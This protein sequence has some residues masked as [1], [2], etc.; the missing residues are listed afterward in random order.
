MSET[1]KARSFTDA[2]LQARRAKRAVLTGALMLIA[3]LVLL[4]TRFVIYM[5]SW[6]DERPVYLAG[7]GV[8]L[9]FTGTITLVA[10]IVLSHISRN[11]TNR[12]LDAEVR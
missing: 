4:L 11:E 5:G 2:G 12:R 1:A 10:G 7:I 8:V 9:A 6:P 3:G